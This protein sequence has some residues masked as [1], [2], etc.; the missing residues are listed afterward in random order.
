MFLVLGS[1]CVELIERNKVHLK[2]RN[3]RCHLCGNRFARRDTLRR[4]V[5]IDCSSSSAIANHPIRHTDD[6]CPKRFELGFREG[7]AAT[8]GRWSLNHFPALARGRDLVVPPSS[9]TAPSSSAI[10]SAA[11]PSYER[12]EFVSVTATASTPAMYAS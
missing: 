4:F 3:H 7:S 8:P 10:P 6:G 1:T 11:F 2:A 12:P 5:S 9:T